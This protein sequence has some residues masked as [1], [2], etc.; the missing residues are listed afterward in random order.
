[1][2]REANFSGAAAVRDQHRF[3]EIRLDT[4]LRETIED[5]AGPL[6]VQQFKGGQ[7]NPTYKL[8]TP[9]KNYVLRRKPPGELV[10]SAHA[11][12][13]EYKVITALGKTDVPVA[14]TYGLCTDE[15]VIGTWFYVMDC[16]EGRV[17]W[18]PTF[19]DAT[20]AERPRYFTAMVEALAKLHKA[21][22]SSIGLDDYGK[23][24]GYM[25]RQ[26]NRWTKQYQADEAA[27][28]IEELDR[29]CEW[30]PSGI[31]ASS[32]IS[33]VHGDY[34]CDNLMFHPTEPCVSAILDWEL[35][36]LGDPLADFTYHLMMYHVPGSMNFG[37][38]DVDFT[39]LNIP[40][41]SDY[42]AHY[43]KL[44]GQP[45]VIDNLDWYLAYNMFRLAAICHGIQG[46]VVRGTAASE[47]AKTMGTRALPLA[48]YA[49]AQAKKAGA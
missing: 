1:M 42:V 7:S 18:G 4:W 5:Y 48:Q 39:A 45:A 12:D 32:G 16:V 2:D 38:S 44:T 27:G 15:S 30:L 28:K 21:D 9:T 31:P 25:A 41:E 13:R 37:L 10:A 33:V 47:H 20:F 43:A 49:W 11:V 19:P 8:I 6:T 26:I 14:K 36:T 29:L 35:S 3:D 34:R 17:I 23:T 22:F 40:T 24:E 46:R